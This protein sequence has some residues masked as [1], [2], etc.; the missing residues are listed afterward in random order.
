MPIPVAEIYTLLLPRIFT[1]DD[2]VEALLRLFEDQPVKQRAT[3]LAVVRVTPV[4]YE[5]LALD[6]LSDAAAQYSY[7]LLP[8]RLADVP[9]LLK[10]TQPVY[11]ARIGEDAA[12]RAKGNAPRRRLV[13]LDE[14]D[15]VIGVLATVYASKSISPLFLLDNVLP[16]VP[17]P[18]DA[19]R[20]AEP[21]TVPPPGDALRGDEPPPILAPSPEL[22]P[23]LSVDT[24]APA[25][26]AH[27]NTRFDWIGPQSS[28]PVGRRVP[29]VVWVG[30]AIAADASRSSRPFTF[31]FAE[32]ATP[33]EFR[34]QVDGDPEMWS[35]K[36]A[37][38][39]MI[40]R[41]PGTTVQEAEF[42]ITAKQAGRDKLHISV[43]RA[44]T[45]ATVQ[46]VWLPVA[47][48]AADE[49]AR[50]EAAPS[51]A[52]PATA[53]RVA[54]SLPLDA[55]DIER[56]QVEIIIQ[57]PNDEA[58]IAVVRADLPSGRVRRSY[59]LPVSPAEVQD[60]IQQL[61]KALTD[62]VGYRLVREGQ[63]VYPFLNP[64]DVTIDLALARK[65]AVPLADA[66]NRVWWT[67]FEG[68]RAD[69]DLRRLADELRTMPEGSRLQAV[70]ESRQFV[71][72]WALL[73]DKPGPINAETLDWAGFWGYRYI[74]DALAP[75]YY[76]PPA[77]A[78]NPPRLVLFFN[79][80]RSLEPFTA[81]QERM[82]EAD[83]AGATVDVV[84]GDDAV[85]QTLSKP[86]EA[87][88]LYCYC[89]GEY[90]GGGLAGGSSLSFSAGRKLSLIEL[91]RLQ[92]PPLP[93]RPLVFLNACEGA[94]R[95]AFSYGG[96]VPFFVETL[97]AR[98]FIGA[99]VKVPQRFAHDFGLA[100]MRYFAQ[101]LPVGTILWQLRRAYL[102]RANNIL[103]F[104]YSLYGLSEMRLAQPL[105]L[106]PAG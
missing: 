62:I 59:R 61:Q 1:P 54:V 23:E 63:A 104:G 57:P 18:T 65:A 6:D 32:E 42:L 40:V 79:D 52:P 12:L 96:F 46:H 86:G 4:S 56:R 10:P 3:Y 78:A 70:L 55:T 43:E 94:T 69:A 35:I 30:E 83:M 60:A 2:S 24:P 67:L 5:V 49:A 66:G 47:A 13:V 39:T 21:P 26:P 15:T 103:G 9:G 50:I 41:P 58:F 98:G 53:E 97:G 64:A 34:V 51:A 106:P 36:V 19:L 45:G 93:G 8:L 37:E 48:A 16:T 92:A 22:S 88:M 38:A 17:P 102:E 84:W 90:V 27:L 20:G 91:Q 100:F 11:A 101:G 44:D 14:T 33:V 72:P 95:E 76:P 82:I 87:T 74:I 99:E 7:A 29:L 73:Y 75:G 31:R 71:L 89:H 81:D 77:I 68:P 105:V 80:E 28:L 25:A 85:K